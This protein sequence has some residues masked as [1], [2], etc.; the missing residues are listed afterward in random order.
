MTYEQI[1]REIKNDAPEL[2]VA[3]EKKL[4]EFRKYAKRASSAY[5]RN[6]RTKRELAM[7]LP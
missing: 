4:P 2:F 6:G 5:G 3:I 1:Y 7:V